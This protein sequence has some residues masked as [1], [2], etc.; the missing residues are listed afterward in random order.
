[1]KMDENT[2]ESGAEGTR[3]NDGTQWSLDNFDLGKRL[4]EGRFGAVYV[5]SENRSKFIVALKILHKSDIFAAAQHQVQREID[6]QFHLHHSNILRLFGYFHDNKRLYL[7]LEYAPGGSVFALLKQK[8]IFSPALSANLVDQLV[9]AL[10][11]M[12]KHGI[13]HRDIKPENML[14]CG[15]VLKLADFGW[16][17][18]VK[19]SQL[20]TYCG[21]PDYLA[22]EMLKEGSYSFEVD[23]WAVGV[24]I[25]EFLTGRAPFDS[26]RGSPR[27]KTLYAN[28]SA[29]RYRLP[30]NPARGAHRT[31][32]AAEIQ[33][34]AWICKQ[35]AL[36]RPEEFELEA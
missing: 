14:L 29:G 17:C 35:K 31:G 33:E 24:T 1:M 34:D 13:L 7:I 21:T 22:P 6:I 9:S 4:G 27:M 11:Y 20:K 32:V 23:I 18:P 12:H 5:A 28:I 25:F 8:K 2:C 19:S 3:R 26:N 10:I 16:A 36:A 30:A 15:K